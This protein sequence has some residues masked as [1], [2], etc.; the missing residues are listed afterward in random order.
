[1]SWLS[2]IS[3]S[4]IRVIESSLLAD[5]CLEGRCFISKKE[6]EMKPFEKCPVCGG[7]LIEKEVEK[8][9]R[10]GKNTA[11]VKISAD[12]CLKCGERLYAEETVRF[13]EQIRHKLENK[14]V[15]EFTLLG[16]TYQVAH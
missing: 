14:E 12:V 1:M 10:G 15:S 7:D 8:L 13:F 5:P 9:L 11:V 6:E 16:R 2:K 4:L 3:K